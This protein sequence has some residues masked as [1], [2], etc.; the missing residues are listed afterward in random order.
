MNVVIILLVLSAITGFAL[1]TS[2]SWLAIAISSA[3]LAVLSSAVLQIQGFGAISGIAIVAACLTVHQVAY[4]AGAC[5]RHQGL[6]DEEADKEPR[7]HRDSDVA[8]RRSQH[9]R[10][11]PRSPELQG[12][13]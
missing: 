13:V 11:H 8:G 6:P 5:M 3:V 10:S 9:Q 12:E 7:D 1:A 2:F 4:L